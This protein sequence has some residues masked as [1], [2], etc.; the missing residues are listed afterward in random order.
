MTALVSFVQIP[1]ENGYQ[2][3]AESHRQCNENGP[4]SLV[5]SVFCHVGGF[6]DAYHDDITAVSTVFIAAFTIILGCFTILLSG[7]T[8]IAADAAKKSPM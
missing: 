5:R 8:K 3:A 4:P 2:N 7:S 6:V 1:K